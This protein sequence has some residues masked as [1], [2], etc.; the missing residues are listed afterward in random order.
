MFRVNDL[1]DL[2]II[3]IADN[4]AL[5]HVKNILLNK[6]ES[7]LEAFICKQGVLSKQ[8]ILLPYKRIIALS[9]D[10]IMVKDMK[11][12]SRAAQSDYG[13]PQINGIEHIVGKF[14]I[15]NSGDIL[16]IVRDIFFNPVNGAIS[17]FEISEG[18]FDE[19]LRGRRV[20]RYEAGFRFSD[21]C[22]KKGE[23]KGGAAFK[24]L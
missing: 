10:G 11:S 4:E 21:A 12:L 5:H 19:L 17:A 1:L 6:Q 24:P 2:P 9:P 13:L 3:S 23:N 16:G 18:Y 22:M 20:I 14:I 8:Y 15:N 7:R